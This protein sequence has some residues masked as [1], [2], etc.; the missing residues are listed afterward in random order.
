MNHATINAMFP[1]AVPEYRFCERRWRFDFAWPDKKVALEI[2]GGTWS[3]SRHTT[4]AGYRNDC[5][6]YNTAATLGWC[7]I[8]ATTDMVKDGSA[9]TDLEKAL[10]VKRDDLTDYPSNNRDELPDEY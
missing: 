2:E 3:R 7:V 5:Y 4:G 8:R 6:K 9:F 1:G 10:K